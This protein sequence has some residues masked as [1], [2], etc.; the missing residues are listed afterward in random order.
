MDLQKR[1]LPSRIECHAYEDSLGSLQDP[2]RIGTPRITLSILSV[3]RTIVNTDL[4]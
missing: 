2:I 1:G 4:N 3:V